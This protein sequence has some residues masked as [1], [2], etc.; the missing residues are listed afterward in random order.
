MKVLAL[1]VFLFGA[2]IAQA[3]TLRVLA[4]DVQGNHDLPKT[5][6]FFCS[7]KYPHQECI[8]DVTTL[9]VILRRYPTADLGPW[10]FAL[11]SS[12]E[13]RNVVTRLSGIPVSSP[14][15]SILENGTTVLEGALFSPSGRRRA[16]LIRMFGTVDRPLLEQAVTHE[17][18]HVLCGEVNEDQA[19]QNGQD[20]FAGRTLTCHAGRQHL[21][22]DPKQ[23]GRTDG[24]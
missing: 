14:A 21:N 9:L 12:D 13:W 2:E 7:E 22:V 6:R 10:N 4:V 1:V 8:R 15:F 3:Q 17:L 19:A 24:R 5:L 18:G 16:E 11:V 20:L 23:R